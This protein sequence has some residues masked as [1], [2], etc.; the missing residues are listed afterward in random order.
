MTIRKNDKRNEQVQFVADNPDE[1]TEDE[2]KDKDFLNDVFWKKF[3]KGFHQTLQSK[4]F[5]IV[6]YL[7]NGTRFSNSRKTRYPKYI[8]YFEVTNNQT[9]E[10]VKVGRKEVDDEIEYRKNNPLNR[11]SDP[12]RNYGLGRE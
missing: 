5:T 9:G 7:W 6:K 4:H 3:G 11:R 10:M 12:K 2:M 1:I 8:P